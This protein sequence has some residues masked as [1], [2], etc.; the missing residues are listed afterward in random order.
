MSNKLCLKLSPEAEHKRG[1]TRETEREREQERE[2]QI[3]NIDKCM[4]GGRE[5]EREERGGRTPERWQQISER[6][7]C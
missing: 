6:E 2:K 4:G 7:C 3:V 5:K 1:T